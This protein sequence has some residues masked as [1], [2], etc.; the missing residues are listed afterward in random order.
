MKTIKGRLDK[1]Q[2]K[3]RFAAFGRSCIQGFPVE[4]RWRRDRGLSEE[5]NLH[6]FVSVL[7]SDAFKT[8]ATTGMKELFAGARNGWA[9][10]R[11]SIKEQ[12]ILVLE[13]QKKAD[14]HAPNMPI[15]AGANN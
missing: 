8:D 13:E 10:P 6:M 2:A 12:Q 14:S 4:A 11:R 7:V 1:I 15:E 3:R 5:G 9:I